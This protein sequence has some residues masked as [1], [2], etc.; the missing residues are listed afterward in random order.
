MAAIVAAGGAV[1]QEEA[2]G[3]V[4]DREPRRGGLLAPARRLVAAL[5]RLGHFLWSRTLHYTSRV[6]N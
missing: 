6:S 3:R 1:A 4:E 5:D 2:L